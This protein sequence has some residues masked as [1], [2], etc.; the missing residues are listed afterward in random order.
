MRRHERIEFKREW[1]EAASSEV[2][3][4]EM[5]PEILA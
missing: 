3:D 1:F 4:A 5:K 2:P